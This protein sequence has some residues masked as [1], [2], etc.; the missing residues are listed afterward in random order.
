ME[1]HPHP[2]GP[3][4]IRI[5]E[6]GYEGETLFPDDPVFEGIRLSISLD[7]VGDDGDGDVAF[8]VE[9]DESDRDVFVRISR[10][11]PLEDGD[12]FAAGKQVFRFRSG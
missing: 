6:G 3:R 4:F 1:S 7:P 2:A 10:G 5:E 9:A 8:L 11:W 12:V